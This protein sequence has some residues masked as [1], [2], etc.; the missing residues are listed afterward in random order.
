MR[1]DV[2]SLAAYLGV[3]FVYFGVPI[4]AHPGRNLIGKGPDPTV[5]VWDFAWWPHAILHWQN[6]I[7]TRA[8]WAPV[9]QNLAWAPSVP[10]LALLASPI[11]LAAGPAVAY[12]LFAILL[13]ALSAWTAYL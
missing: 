1:R 7:L 3:S 8:I 4:A 12:N 11:T 2:A 13:P 10:G 6:P 9:G 5:L